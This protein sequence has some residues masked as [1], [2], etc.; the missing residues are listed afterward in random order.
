V[1]R[2]AGDKAHKGCPDSDGD[3]LYD[4]EDACPRE[5]GP[6]ENKGCPYKDTDGD[7]VLDKDDDCPNTFGAKDNRG[8]PKLAKKELE[9]V[10]YAFENLEFETGKDVIKKVS[11][12]SLNG[13][14]KLLAE[15]H[16]MA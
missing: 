1:R 3:G 15:K 7:G 2:C 9:V 13:L 11:F 16:R 8:C 6:I 4:N 12:I 5:A 14:A 10:K